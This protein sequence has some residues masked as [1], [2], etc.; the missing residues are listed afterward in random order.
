MPDTILATLISLIATFNALHLVDH[1]LRGDFHWPLEGQSVGFLVV[2]VLT[3]GV[4]GLGLV[5]YRT[6]RVGPRFW[7]IIGLVG[8]AFGWPAHFSPF[9]D[10]PPAVI[11]AA[12]A[13]RWAEGLALAGLVALM[14]V[15]LATTVY[16]GWR[17]RLQERR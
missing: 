1:V 6:C 16:A 9:I 4:L 7:T 5:L 15:L 13:S 12:Y 8:L 3:Y 14:L 2:T 17:W 10:Q 11:L